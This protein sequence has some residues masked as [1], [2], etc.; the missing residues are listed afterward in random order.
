MDYFPNCFNSVQR[1]TDP[2]CLAYI[3][4]VTEFHFFLRSVKVFFSFHS[5]IALR[6]NTQ[7]SSRESK[8]DKE[9]SWSWGHL[10]KSAKRNGMKWVPELIDILLNCD[11]SSWQTLLP[12]GDKPCWIKWWW[13]NIILI[14]LRIGRW[15]HQHAILGGPVSNP[16]GSRT[17]HAESHWNWMCS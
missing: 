3:T 2:P 4:S 6:L 13:E 7:S 17:T 9:A 16:A 12:W 8:T 1:F 14:Y 5:L 11:F 15:T 10:T